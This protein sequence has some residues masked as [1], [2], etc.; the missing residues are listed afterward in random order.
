MRLQVPLTSVMSVKFKLPLTTFGRSLV[1][2]QLLWLLI[3]S[4]PS[5]TQIR[6]L[7]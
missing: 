6:S 5:A 1:L 4:Q 2:L 7:S 3:A